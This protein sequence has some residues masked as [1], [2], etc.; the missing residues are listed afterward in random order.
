MSRYLRPDEWLSSPGGERVVMHVRPMCDMV[1]LFAPETQRTETMS[2][3]RLR[4]LLATGEWQRRTSTELRGSAHDL[5]RA[6]TGAFKRQEFY[7]ALSRAARE[8]MSRGYS[9]AGA[10]QK[11]VEDKTLILQDGEPV[12]MCSTR[13]AF[14]ILKMVEIGELA[15]LPNYH[16][17]GNRTSRYG[18]EITQLVL[19][20][21]EQQ[22]AVPHSRIT[23]SG[24]HKIINIRARDMG[25]I[26]RDGA[27]S[28]KFVRRILVDQWHPD[29]DYK[30]LE[31]RVARSAKAIAQ[32]RIR[33]GGVLHRVEMDSMC[34]P[35]LIKTDL[36]VIQ[37]PWVM[38]A[39]DCETSYPVSWLMMLASPTE[40]DT[41]QCVERLAYPK[42]F[43]LKELKVN[44]SVDPFGAPINLIID[45]GPENRGER[46]KKLAS[47]GI[48]PEFPLPQSPSLKPFIERL[49]GS[50]KRALEMLPGCTRFDGEDGAR[51]EVAQHD[52]LLSLEELEHWV[53]RWLFEVWPNHPLERFITADY[54]VNQTLGAT[55]SE[56]WKNAEMRSLLPLSPAREK[57]VTIRYLETERSLSPKTGVPFEGFR[58]RGGNLRH[59]IN[60]YGPDSQVKVRYNP[61]DYRY[62]YVE[63]KKTH[64][65]VELI[66][67]EVDEN[68][69]AFSFSEAKARR[70]SVKDTY[71]KPHPQVEAF[72]QDMAEK[73]LSSNKH[74]RSE[75]QRETR[76]LVRTAEAIQRGKNHPGP[77]TE[78]TPLLGMDSYIAEDDI[79]AFATSHKTSR[80]SGGAG[81]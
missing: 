60:Q 44:A 17:R 49:N 56:R 37:N 15:L 46:I 79:P 25:L 6:S 70:K 10:I 73:V 47:L 40:E 30:R 41:L 81:A 1:E 63:D 24:L 45:N 11:L 65:W 54:E 55:P 18:E 2:L 26:P 9:K 7:L 29:L 80:H 76:E 14:R 75:I 51:T 59:L 42:Q 22:Y 67:A 68:T 62:V 31:P 58:F 74:K 23:V 66:N 43:L 4:Q 35:M 77:H 39:I 20:L 8:L 61:S 21:I 27:L 13:Q 16:R 38:L 36:G 69:P 50:L 34:L 72:D 33:P 52:E 5:Q 71:A 28:R 12:P 19:A 48:N 3:N 32:Y 64:E 78:S 53:V 57:W